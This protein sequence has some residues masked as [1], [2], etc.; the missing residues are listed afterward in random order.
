M[1]DTK[2]ELRQYIQDNFIMGS[3]GTKFA[4]GDSFMELH[5]LDSTGFLELISHLEETYG[6]SVKDEEMIPENL[7]SLAALEAF[8][9]RKRAA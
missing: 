3:T 7:D 2:A 1:A 6:F 4:D 9:A 8:V 5:I